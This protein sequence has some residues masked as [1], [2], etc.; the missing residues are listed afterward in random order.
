[1]SRRRRWRSGPRCWGLGATAT[2]DAGAEVVRRTTGIERLDYG[3]HCS[4]RCRVATC[5]NVADA[6]SAAGAE[7]VYARRR[8]AWR[9]RSRA[10]RCSRCRRRRH[11]H[12]P[13]GQQGRGVVAAGGDQ[14]PGRAPGAG[15]G[16]KTAPRSPTRCR[17]S[18]CRRPPAPSRRAAR[19]RCDLSGRCSATRS[20]STSR[21]KRRRH[22][23]Q[24]PGNRTHDHGTEPTDSFRPARHAVA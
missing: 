11:Q 24:H 17:A 19:S 13:A 22:E 14:R 16:V 9:I 2:M 18:P 10:R 7:P 21:P 5:H 23:Q 3:G 8:R 4:R 1:M 12:L 15:R 20:R 6:A